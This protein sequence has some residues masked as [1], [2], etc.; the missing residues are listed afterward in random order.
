MI[1]N[2]VAQ[3]DRSKG[4]GSGAPV[5]DIEFEKVERRH[6]KAAVAT[7]PKRKIGTS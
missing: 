4:G 2:L 7:A 5:W 1:E 6:V 3:N